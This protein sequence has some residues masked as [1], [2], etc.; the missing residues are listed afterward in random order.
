MR[1]DGPFV[2]D[3]SGSTASR[4]H[5]ETE[6]PEPRPV[7]P[8]AQPWSAWLEELRRQGEAL[9]P[10]AELD[11]VEL[12]GTLWRIVRR[13]AERRGFLLNTDHLSDRQ[14][15]ERL[16][17][18]AL[19]VVPARPAGGRPG[20]CLLD[21]LGRGSAEDTHAWLRYYAT[22]TQRRRWR[23]RWPH[24]ALPPHKTPPYDR[25]RYLPAWRP[26]HGTD[27]EVPAGERDTDEAASAAA[28]D[29]DGGHP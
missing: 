24:A 11:D 20:A 16:R 14:L 13:L 12:R 22:E 18:G 5:G 15:Y 3:R 8:P 4:R 19:R 21:L 25:D 10:P 29:D 27:D 26:P 7:K 9:P 17:D 2:P 6:A 28:G 23:C 1:S